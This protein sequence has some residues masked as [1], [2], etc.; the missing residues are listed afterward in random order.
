MSKTDTNYLQ[1]SIRI[2]KQYKALAEKAFNQ[3]PENG[4]MWKP[5]AESNSVYLIIKHM[6]GN[7]LSRWTDFL[8]TDGEKEW[9][10]R[11]EEFEQEQSMNKTQILAMWESGWACL[12]AAIE[13]LHDNDLGKIVYIRGEAH[14]VLEAINRQIAHYSYHVGQLVFLCKQ[15]QSEQWQTLSIARGKSTDFNNSMKNVK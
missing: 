12:F 3:L 2:F 6:S 8:T 5:D 4:L 1:S 10:N 15:I 7:M 13:P 9:R 14:S 11:D